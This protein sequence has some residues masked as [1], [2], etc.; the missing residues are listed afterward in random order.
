LEGNKNGTQV[1]EVH[2]ELWV[3]LYP[4]IL[5]EYNDANWVSDTKDSKSTNGYVFTT[6]LWKSF[7][8]TCIARSMIELEFIA[9]NKIEKEPNGFRIS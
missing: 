6:M 3:T 1:F 7:K 4:T 9:L 2:L 8:Q 5:K